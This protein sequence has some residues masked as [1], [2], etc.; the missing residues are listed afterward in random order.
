MNIDD[1]IPPLSDEIAKRNG[2]VTV[3]KPGKIVHD[4]NIHHS[5]IH[6]LNELAKLQ[7]KIIWLVVNVD[8]NM[9]NFS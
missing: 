2:N 3:R 4:L 5:I 1:L 8:F 7:N 6:E 9:Y